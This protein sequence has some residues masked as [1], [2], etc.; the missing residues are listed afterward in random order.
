MSKGVPDSSCDPCATT[1]QPTASS[2]SCWMAVCHCSVIACR[3]HTAMQHEEGKCII[4]KGNM[5]TR[6]AGGAFVRHSDLA[7]SMCRMHLSKI[8][9]LPGIH[10]C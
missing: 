4:L 7:D 6:Q 5:C 3:S 2:C 9:W 1:R 10:Q 8:Q